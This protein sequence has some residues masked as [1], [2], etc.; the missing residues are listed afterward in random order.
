MAAAH[1]QRRLVVGASMARASVPLAVVIALNVVL[2]AAQIVVGTSVRSLALVSDG[3]HTLSDALAAYVARLA[4]SCEARSFD[5]FVLPFGYDRAGTIGALANVAALEALCLSI[6]L[7]ALCRLWRPE[8]VTDLRALALASALGV[9]VN[10][11]S[12]ALA[13]AGVGGAHVHLGHGSRGRRGCSAY[14]RLEN[15]SPD[16]FLSP[17]KGCICCD[18]GGLELPA[19]DAAASGAGAASPPGAADAAEAP[20]APSPKKALGVGRAALVAHLLGD[21]ATCLVVFVEALVLRYGARR[22]LSRRSFR[23]LRSYLDPCVSLLMAAFI[24]RAAWP[25]GADAAMALLDRAPSDEAAA[26][27]KLR[28]AAI[29]G[30]ASVD[31]AALLRLRDAPPN[32]AGLAKLTVAELDAGPG[33]A[34]AARAVF[35]AFGASEHAYVDVSV[36]ESESDARA[37]RHSKLATPGFGWARNHRPQPPPDRPPSPADIV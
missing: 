30:V 3:A 36:S 32:H 2:A 21:A 28:L 8:P 37:R 5:R 13:V 1:A 9:L 14:A 34:A 24:G 19:P 16:L 33:V 10:G 26:E 20:D 25:V 17:G 35:A 31:A 6:G 18:V 23:L 4:E 29:R 7:S 11:A 15:A 27:L 12:A 22:R